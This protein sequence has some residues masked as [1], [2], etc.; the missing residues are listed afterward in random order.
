M[1]VSRHLPIWPAAPV[2]IWTKPDIKYINLKG[3]LL[4]RP[5]LY[6]FRCHISN[7]F[8]A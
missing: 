5:F 4:N 7:I 6:D 1:T 3:W 2:M 8:E